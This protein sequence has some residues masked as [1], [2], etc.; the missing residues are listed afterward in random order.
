MHLDSMRR[1]FRSLRRAPA[2]TLISVV[3]VALGVGAGTALFSVVKAV[4]LNPL[5]FPEPN[6]LAYIAEV[7]D[8]GRQM[9]VPSA[10]FEDWQRENRSFVVMTA[11]GEGPV[12]AGGG[13][14]PER[15]YGAYVMQ[16]FFR[17]MGIQ[18]AMG[19][20]FDPAEQKFRAAGTVVLGDGLWRRAYGGDPRILGKK[21]KLMGQPFT[22]IGVMPSGFEYPN[23]SELWIA[24]GAF[25]GNNKSRTSPN[26]WVGGRLRPGV[27]ISQAQAD[28]K[29][30]SRRL[31]QEYPSPFIAKDA[32]GR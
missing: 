24:A 18:P 25:F 14:S 32:A 6:R 21:I 27:T 3:T 22:V 1:A 8:S 26:F 10:N 5:P 9:Q 7:N 4:L 28:L 23:G 16:D 29:A 15:T 13:E 19:R 2:L 20:G 30:I 12:N 31:K 11:S 17:V